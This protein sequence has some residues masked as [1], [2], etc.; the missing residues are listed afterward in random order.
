MV[1]NCFQDREEFHFSCNER[2]AREERAGKD[3]RGMA[4]STHV[5]HPS[6]RRQQLLGVSSCLLCSLRKWCWGQRRNPGLPGTVLNLIA[7]QDQLRTSLGKCVVP[8]PRFPGL[9]GLGCKL[10]MGIWGSLPKGAVKVEMDSCQLIRT[11]PTNC[12][13]KSQH[14]ILRAS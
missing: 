3:G 14:L 7:C 4:I 11:W 8:G 13:F 6:P 2:P 9:H 5:P 1:G 12:V 10:T